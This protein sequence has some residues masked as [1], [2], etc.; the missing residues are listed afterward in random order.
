MKV[1][2][3]NIFQHGIRDALSPPCPCVH[4]GEGRKVKTDIERGTS[5][6]DAL[7]HW[8]VCKLTLLWLQ[9]YPKI[10]K[11]EQHV[12]RIWIPYSREWMAGKTLV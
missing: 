7:L 3:G 1:F 6:S 11:A 2:D 12:L 9:R 4:V 5:E 10:Y 8:D